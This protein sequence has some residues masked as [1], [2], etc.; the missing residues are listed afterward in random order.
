MGSHSVWHIPLRTVRD[1]QA[2]IVRAMRSGH[3]VYVADA[4]TDEDLAEVARA[5]V[6][7]DVVLTCGSAGLAGAIADAA[8]LP[9][10]ARPVSFPPIKQGPALVVAGSRHPATIAQ[11]GQ[12]EAIGASVVYLSCEAAIAG[13]PALEGAVRDAVTRL[14]E[15]SDVILALPGAI[16]G[17]PDRR[18]VRGLARAAR[19]LGDSGQLGGLT[20]TGGDT[21]VAALSAFGSTTISVQGEIAPG[22]PWGRL[23]EGPHKGLPVVTK[24][25]G[26]GHVDALA[27]S[28]E[29]V[30]ELSRDPVQ[31]A[32]TGR[33]SRLAH[34][35]RRR[36]NHNSRRQN[37]H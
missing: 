11:L 19:R 25:G 31:Q 34:G 5:A 26:F 7:S 20:L 10:T 9:H 1:G 37:G 27:R 4:E 6:D 33:P 18:L 23:P 16:E 22:I 15:D 14:A 30:R 3:G 32:Q 28:I 12:A 13:G 2:A 17:R 29:W 8:A 21:A 36:L 35:R 24:A